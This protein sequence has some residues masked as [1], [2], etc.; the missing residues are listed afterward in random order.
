[1][2]T[3]ILLLR[4][5]NVGGKNRLPMKEL[6]Q[7]LEALKLE[8]VKTYIQSGNVAFE[9][10][11]QLVEGLGDRTTELGEAH[12]ITAAIEASHGFKP[13][14]LI[15]SAAELEEAIASNPFPEAKAEPKSLHLYFLAS[16]PKSPDLAA[17]EQAK[18]PSEAF[19]LIGKVFYLHAP[20][21]IG[22]SKLAAIAEQ[23]LSVAATA[24]NWRT[25]QQLW[26]MVQ[27]N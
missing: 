22:R 9:A 13:R 19:Q 25:V 4:G 11:E 21:G 20:D 16:A 1:M 26:E 18:A 7:A 10:S 8:N 14:C 24:R 23:K 17:I 3:W 6:V 2:A 27:A 12:R 15:L 5:I